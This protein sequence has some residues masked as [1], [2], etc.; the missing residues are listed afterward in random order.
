M[1]KITWFIAIITLVGIS[2]LTSCKK[3]GA[4][5]IDNIPP[6][7]SLRLQGGGMSKTFES[8]ED[9]SLGQYNMKPNT[10]YTFTLVLSDTGGVRNLELRL[11][12]LFSAMTVNSS[13]TASERETTNTKYYTISSPRDTTVYFKSYLMTGDFVTPDASNTSYSL[14]IFAIGRDFRPNQSTLSI[15]C[16]ISNNPAGGYGWV[17]F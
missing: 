9:Y 15:N 7:M 1:K 11:P 3:E 5:T 4:A 17:L 10:K 6:T 14:G 12:T 16:D 8:T 2:T 13:P